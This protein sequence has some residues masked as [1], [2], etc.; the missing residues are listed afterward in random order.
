MGMVM[1]NPYVVN[2]FLILERTLQ[3][4]LEDYELTEV[5][6]HYFPKSHSL[7]NFLSLLF[8]VTSRITLTYMTTQ[9]RFDN[10]AS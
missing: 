3:A 4:V 6:N 8:R 1:G 5:V 10:V 7:F 9:H 2:M